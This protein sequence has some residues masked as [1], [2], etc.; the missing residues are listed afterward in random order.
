MPRDPLVAGAEPRLGPPPSTPAGLSQALAPLAAVY[1]IWGSTYLAIRVALEGFPP[2]VLSGIRFIMAGAAIL[3]F[4]AVRGGALPDRRQWLAAAPVGALLFVGGNGFVALAQVHIGSGV[5]AVVVA[6]MPLWMALFAVMAGE[7]PRPRE[8]FGIALGFGAVALLSSGGDLRA[9]TGATLLLLL[10]P[11]AW[12]AGSI[13]SRRAPAGEGGLMAVVAAQMLLG[14]A[15]ALGLGVLLGERIAVAPGPRAGIA[16]L[17]LTVF[18]TLGFVAYSW[19][20]RNVRPLLATSY[21]FVNPLIAVLLGALLGGEQ[22]D[23]STMVAAPAVA[24]AVAMTI[25]ARAR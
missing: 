19:L 10:S 16:L 15:M 9:D 2:L 25:T 18:G 5:A 20:L 13:L 22:L 11:L 24:V 17:Y 21:A 3:M 14:G 1:V 7:R 4:V 23:W 12:A 8:W 6:T